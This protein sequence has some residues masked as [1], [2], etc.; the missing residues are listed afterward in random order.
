MKHHLTWFQ[1]Y[2]QEQRSSVKA[3]QHDDY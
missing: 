1:L 3:N 2:E